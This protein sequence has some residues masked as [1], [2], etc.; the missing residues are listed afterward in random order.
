MAY[1]DRG[2]DRPLR[3]A[4][5]RELTEADKERHIDKSA[6]HNFERDM[7]ISPDPDADV[8]RRDLERET[9]RYLREYMSD[10]SSVSAVYAIHPPNDRVNVL[11][12]QV[13]LTGSEQDLYM[14]QQDI[15]RERER[16]SRRLEPSIE[17]ER[18]REQEQELSHDRGLSL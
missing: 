18:E 6:R 15:Q 8:S 3:N 2:A 5:G 17:R 12:A 14:D 10:R 1:L 7:T 11:H 4:A 9:E 16:L 13:S